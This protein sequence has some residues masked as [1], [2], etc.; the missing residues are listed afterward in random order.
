MLSFSKLKV[1]LIYLL[2][3]IISFFFSFN[4]QDESN[5]YV[6]KKINLGLDLQGGSYLL[7]EV[8]TEQL[9]EERL[10]NK[11]LPLKKTLRENNTNYTNFIFKNKEITFNIENDKYEELKK[12]IFS[13]NNNILSNHMFIVFKY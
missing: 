7:L 13:Q 6:D 10:Q 3:I 5:L 4:F 2:F 8:E 1:F 11:V 9:I 12:V